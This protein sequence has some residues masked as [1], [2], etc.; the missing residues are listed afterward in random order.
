MYANR[1]SCYLGLRI[2]FSSLLPQRPLTQHLDIYPAHALRKFVTWGEKARVGEESLFS[3]K[4]KTSEELL[5]LSKRRARGTFHSMLVRGLF[6]R[7]PR[8]QAV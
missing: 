2:S 3:G 1:I 8:S 7:I 5:A 4:G 6:R